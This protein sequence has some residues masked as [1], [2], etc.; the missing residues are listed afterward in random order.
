LADKPADDSKIEVNIQ[1]LYDVL[2]YI[3]E[4]EQVIKN[5]SGDGK[6]VK[7]KDL[8]DIYHAI[9]DLVK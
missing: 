1:L 6:K 8:P 7:I 4:K 9:K 3:K 2:D 5:I